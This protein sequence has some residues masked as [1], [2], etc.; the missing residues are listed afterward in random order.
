MPTPAH[1][2]TIDS[3]L[4]VLS[5]KAFTLSLYL[6]LPEYSTQAGTAGQE[7]IQ[8]RRQRLRQSTVG[9][10][11]QRIALF[12][13]GETSVTPEAAQESIKFV[14]K[15]LFDHPFMDDPT[16]PQ[17]FHRTELGRMIAEAY[18]RLTAGL[19]LLT[20]TQ[21]YQEMRVSRQAI[22]NFVRNSKLT[23]LY[24]YGKMM[25]FAHEVEALKT[26]RE[27]TKALRQAANTEGSMDM[28]N[29][30]TL[31]FQLGDEISFTE[32]TLD[33]RYTGGDLQDLKRENGPYHQYKVVDFP[34]SESRFYDW[35]RIGVR[36]DGFNGTCPLYYVRCKD[37]IGRELRPMSPTIIKPKDEHQNAGEEK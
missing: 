36:K 25:L 13:E 17:G 28:Q 14:H 5:T 7:S 29:Y 22:Y 27:M 3:T 21:A 9:Y 2:S 1:L 8:D 19:E 15:L 26:Q 4:L 20:P 35:A 11:L 32:A 34:D 31:N 6:K 37:V 23:P 30:Y 16:P 33:A 18:V 10:H 12:A 24:L